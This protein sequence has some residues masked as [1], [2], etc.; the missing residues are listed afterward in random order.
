MSTSFTPT[1]GRTAKDLLPVVIGGDIGAYALGLEM[2]E[3]YGVRSI[4]LS[5]NP[6][7]VIKHSKIMVPH[8]I[9]RHPTDDELVGALLKL[10]K[11][12]PS[13]AIVLLSNNDA[14]VGVLVRNR[15]RFGSQF[16]V[17]Y[18]HEGVVARLGDKAAF[19]RLC[20]DVGVR[21]PRTQVVD[22]A[23]LGG[24]SWKAPEVEVGYPLVAKPAL[25]AQ[26]EG[27]EVEGKRK[28][29]FLDAP[30][31]VDRLWGSLAEA[32]FTGKFV[33]QEY[34]PGDDTYLRSMTF[35]VDSNGRPTLQAGARVLL[36]DP[37]PM[38]VGNPIAM[39][40]DPLMAFAPAALRVLR[41]SA[42]RGFANFDIKLHPETWEP[43]FLEVNPRPGRNSYYVVAG[44]VNPMQVMVDDLYFGEHRALAVAWRKALYSLIP[45][46]LIRE[47]VHSPFISAEATGLAEVGLLVDPLKS[48]FETHPKRW[49][50]VQAQRLNWHRKLGA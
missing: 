13:K 38:M 25:Q 17:P 50:A 35:Y 44:G 4:V 19:A 36:Q 1:K 32:G 27:V 24:R 6:V 20:G 16:V 12:N 7:A 39:I 48:P 45:L 14:S 10:G 18:P 9:H 21:T 46:S 49:L 42:Y 5:A 34:I 29:Y 33:L 31:D 41:A 23:G 40:T 47:H 11:L 22:L 3:A 26:W 15:G 2:F 8:Y 43:Y 30:A 37:T 28:V